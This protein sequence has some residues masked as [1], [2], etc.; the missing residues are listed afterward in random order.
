MRRFAHFAAIDW[1]G[2][3]GEY[4][5]SIAVAATAGPQDVVMIDR[6][7]GWSRADVRDWLGHQADT[8]ADVLIGIDLSLGFPFADAGAF[9]PGWEATPASAK[10]LWALVDQ[11]CQE[12][13][14]LAASS[15]VAHPNIAPHFRQHGLTGAQF[16]GSLGR[17]RVTEIGQ[18]AM[19]LRP[20]GCF[21]LVGAAQV[22]KASLTGMR[23]LNQLGGR[24]PVWPFDPLPEAGPVIVEIYTS[25]AAMAAGRRAG[26]SKMRDAAALAHALAAL[27]ARA[28]TPA[29]LT[30]HACDALVTAAW[31]RK[32][33]C[34]AELWTPKSLSATIATTEGWTFG[35]V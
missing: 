2:A 32:I 11:H 14:H 17:M 5:P 8:G 1:S 22:G 29:K 15:F 4:L 7:R 3:V 18:A 12:D 19:G 27:G 33:A 9:F 25:L 23:V 24:I 31:L 34:R 13:P 10:A 28:V 20:Y 6:S 16:S 30:D 21:N 26:A 35:V